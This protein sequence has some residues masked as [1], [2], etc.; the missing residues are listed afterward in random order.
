MD[1]F[2]LVN[3]VSQEMTASNTVSTIHTLQQDWQSPYATFP[4]PW[5]S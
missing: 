4:V 2:I 1:H 3:R 5:V